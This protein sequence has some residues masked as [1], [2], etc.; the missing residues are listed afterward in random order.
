[1]FAQTEFEPAITG[2]GNGFTIACVADELLA[3]QTPALTTLLNQVVVVKA[4]GA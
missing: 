1:M 3:G 2:V 4:P